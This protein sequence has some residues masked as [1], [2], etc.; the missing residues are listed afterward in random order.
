MDNKGVRWKV[1]T[2]TLCWTRV[3]CMVP[4]DRWGDWDLT[5]AGNE[6]SALECSHEPQNDVLV[7]DSPHMAQ[8]SHKLVMKP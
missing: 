8:W 4:D 1:R 2:E 3:A 6:D 7:S 5:R